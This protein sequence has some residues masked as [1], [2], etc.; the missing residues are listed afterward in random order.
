MQ[1]DLAFIFPG[2]GSQRV[3]MLADAAEEF[4]EVA[5]TFAEASEA[6]GFD[7]WDMVQ[8]GAAETLAL[9]ENTQ[10]LLLCSS[11]ALW[12][13][14]EQAGGPKPAMVAGHSLGELSALCCVGFFSLADAVVAVR[15]RGRA[16]QTAVPVGVGAMAAILG[17]DDVHR[18]FASSSS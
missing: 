17:L 5:A 9:T 4:P 14:W 6:L 16:M 12:R 18:V 10:P 8:N 1:G 13:A 15:E 11:V 2:Q 3:G 7:V